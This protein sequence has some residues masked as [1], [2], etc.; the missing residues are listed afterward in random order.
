MTVDPVLIVPAVVGALALFALLV[1]RLPRRW[2]V[3]RRLRGLSRQLDSF[4]PDER[5]RAGAAV[6]ELGLTRRT[7]NVLLHALS[8]EEDRR[9]S[10]RSRWPSSARTAGGSA[11]GGCGD[12][13]DGLSTMLVEHG[14]PCIR[15][16][17]GNSRGSD[18]RSRGRHRRRNPE[19][20]SRTGPVEKRLADSTN[21]H[22][23]AERA[24]PVLELGWIPIHLHD[25]E[26]SPVAEGSWRDGHVARRGGC[27][28][29]PCPDRLRQ[30]TRR[31]RRDE[32]KTAREPRTGRR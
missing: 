26:P 7:A 14:H 15:D 8:R 3:R 23:P 18:L 27:R 12:S 19:N 28:R 11:G 10:S 4:D 17:S 5:A 29:S 25:V 31:G 6:A 21:R 1:W 9:V 22:L 30:R 2:R 20:R 13:A 16:S 32:G 24:E